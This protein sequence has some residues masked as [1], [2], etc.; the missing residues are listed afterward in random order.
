[1]SLLSINYPLIISPLAS[2][3]NGLYP[4]ADY[5]ARCAAALNHVQA[6]R[7]GEVFRRSNLLGFTRA[8]GTNTI[9]RWRFNSGYA[10]THLQC[11]GIMGL[12]STSAADPAVTLSITKSGGATQTLTIYGGNTDS[13]PADGPSEWTSFEHTFDIDPAS[14]YECSAASV[15]YGA[16]LALSARQHGDSEID[17]ATNYLTE[18]EPGG[19]LP[20]LDVNQQQLIEGSGRLLRRNRGLHANWGLYNGAARTRANA[21][22]I[23]LIN[24]SSA[25][26]PTSTSPGFRFVTT[27]HNTASRTAVPVEISV[28]GN[29]NGGDSAVTLRNTAGTDVLI[30]DL[31][32]STDQWFTNT[33]TIDVSSG[34]KL[35]LGFYSAGGGVTAT[36]YAVSIAE[37]EA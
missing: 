17:D 25:S 3:K 4:E 12:A 7:G 15:D 8:S 6:F 18:W 26:P 27:A 22:W 28:Y 13:A 16:L 31:D 24:N 34:L 21:T 30:V 20:I 5:Y 32:S 29:S 19:T 14:V 10:Q 23:N 36:V 11:I 37:Y 33:G 1:M 35:D 9:W 2:A